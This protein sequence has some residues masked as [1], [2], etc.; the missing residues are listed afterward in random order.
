LLEL[1]AS[2]IPHGEHVH[3]A[4]TVDLAGQSL[5]THVAHLIKIF[6][7]AV[8]VQPIARR[9]VRFV[10]L[11][12]LLETCCIHQSRVRNTHLLSDDSRTLH[13]IDD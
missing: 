11:V 4:G 8:C 5:S 7:I 6:A 10:P 12:A 2:L 9:K 3:K 1:L 13:A